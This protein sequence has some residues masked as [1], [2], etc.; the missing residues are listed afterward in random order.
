MKVDENITN[1]KKSAV[2]DLL[3]RPGVTG[4]DTGFK[5]IGGQR[6]D[7]IVIRVFVQEKKN[8]PEAERIPQTINGV[9]TDVI[10]CDP[11]LLNGFLNPVQGGLIIEDSN[12]KHGTGGMVVFN[13][14]RGVGQPMLLT[15]HH[16]VAGID[17]RLR[18]GSAMFQPN[19]PNPPFPPDR[20]VG[21]VDRGL[22][23]GVVD[24][25]VV[26]I[27]W[28]G[29][30]G[31]IL[32]IG[33]IK[34]VNQ[35]TLN[36]RVR[37]HGGTTNLTI[38]TVTGIDA[39]L[40]LAGPTGVTR[41][42]N[43]ISIAGDPVT[44]PTF[45][46]PGD[47]GSVVINETGNVIGMVFAGDLGAGKLTFANHINAILNALDLGVYNPD[48]EPVGFFRSRHTAT[49]DH[50]YTTSWKDVFAASAFGWVFERMECAVYRSPQS[51][52]VPLHGYYN[53]ANHDHFYTIN[54][55]ELGSG[56]GDWR[57]DGVTG[58]V[59]GSAQP[60]T[61]PL[62]RYVTKDGAHHFY[63]AN[64]KEL[65]SGN[66]HWK[67]EGIQCWVYPKPIPHVS[68]SESGSGHF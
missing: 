8:V 53:D 15:C 25:A 4:V 3:K 39:D 46:L 18:P 62:H 59:Y 31:Q 52:T 61:I 13:G 12:S 67:Y 20:R 42:T 22:F 2:E 57:Y 7:Q 26:S 24:A 38:G 47:S 28:P 54:F 9:P 66:E 33:P 68:I 60:N 14:L 10:Q 6:T 32:D 43:Q 35:A 63:N 48:T 65:G 11:K 34:G 64:F 27:N 44:S 55:G 58:Y 19:P 50:F 23:N 29:I 51:G 41:F 45:A 1:A 40:L 17:G 30:S 49:D 16:V 37:K 36:M 56:G 5:I 21:L